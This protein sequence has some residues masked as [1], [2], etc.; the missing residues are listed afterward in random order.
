MGL[1]Y[2]D[3]PKLYDAFMDRDRF[4]TAMMCAVR[5]RVIKAVP[6][7][8]N[9]TEKDPEFHIPK[10]YIRVWGKYKA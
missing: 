3:N 9:P 5:D 8:N 10:R 2:R 1:A 6:P 4:V 7:I